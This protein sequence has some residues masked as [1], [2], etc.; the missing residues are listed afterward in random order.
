MGG[1]STGN[2][3]GALTDGLAFKLIQVP[4]CVWGSASYYFAAFCLS[5]WFCGFMLLFACFGFVWVWLLVL[6]GWLIVLKKLGEGKEHSLERPQHGSD[7]LFSHSA[8]VVSSA[9]S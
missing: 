9:N 8:E 1:Y 4:G 3:P 6:E 7:A 5:V 2:Y